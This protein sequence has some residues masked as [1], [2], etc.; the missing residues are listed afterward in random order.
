[1]PEIFEELAGLTRL[2]HEPARLAILSALAACQEANF[3]FL[4]RLTG[5]SKGN[6]SSHLA[7]LEQ[8]GLVQ[9][10]KHFVGKTPS[11]AV[12][13]TDPGRAALEQHWQQLERLRSAAQQWVP[14][15]GEA[16]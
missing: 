4:Q 11:T 12:R 5:L 13:L 16:S 9:I 3:L 10:D 15:A 8:G 14:Q 6:L 2:V 7:K 1:M